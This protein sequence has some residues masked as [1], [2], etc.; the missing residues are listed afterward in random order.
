MPL[1]GVLRSGAALTQNLCFIQV[2]IMISQGVVKRGDG[3]SAAGPAHSKERSD[4]VV[5]V[6]LQ[7]F[8]TLS[9]KFQKHIKTYP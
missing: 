7:F 5:A 1:L 6:T 2:S 3:Q 4:A 9:E 8:K